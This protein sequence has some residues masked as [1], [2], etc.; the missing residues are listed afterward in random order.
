MSVTHLTVV[1]E[2]PAEAGAPRIADRV[3]RLQAEARALAREHIETLLGRLAEVARMAAEVAQGGEA[4]PVGAREL[5]ARFAEHASAQ[6]ETLRLIT[7]R[8][9][10]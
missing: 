10:R 9:T 4:Y 6:V 3:R 5:C 2:A 7:D 1:E 8:D